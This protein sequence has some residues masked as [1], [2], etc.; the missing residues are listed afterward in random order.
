MS[1]LYKRYVDVLMIM[2]KENQVIPAAI[3]WDTPN[4]K[5][6]YRIDKFK[7]RGHKASVVG[8]C[9]IL[10]ECMIQGK[11]RK[12]YYAKDGWFIESIKP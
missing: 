4:G 2:T 10:F 7:S 8:G 9:G 11:P 12:L 6:K 1:K 5:K 3:Y